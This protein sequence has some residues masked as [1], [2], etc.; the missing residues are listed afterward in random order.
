MSTN[1]LIEENLIEE[2]WKLIFD[3]TRL[4]HESCNMSKDPTLQFISFSQF[5]VLI[6]IFSHHADALKLKDIANELHQTKASTSTTINILVQKGLVE[7]CVD[8]KDHRAVSIRLTELGKNIKNQHSKFFTKQMKQLL[9]NVPLEE[10][11]IFFRVM[12]IL[13]ENL[14]QKVEKK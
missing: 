9:Q 8:E 10:Q 11:K 5:R 4:L 13:Y 3:I 2:S 1:E 14:H 6:T 7:S 12:K